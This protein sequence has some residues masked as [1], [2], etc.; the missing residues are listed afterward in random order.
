VFEDIVAFLVSIIFNIAM[1]AAKIHTGRAPQ[2]MGS[3][4]AAFISLGKMGIVRDHQH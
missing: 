4:Q 2:L 3:S 1:P